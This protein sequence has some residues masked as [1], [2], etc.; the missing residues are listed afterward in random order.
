MDT[1]PQ[2]DPAMTKLADLIDAASIGMLTTAESGGSLRSRPLG[3][4]QIDSE[5]ALWFFTSIASHKVDD[6]DQHHK[7]NLS[8]ANPSRQDYV[9]I[10]GTA[11]LVNDRAKMKQLWTPWIEPWFPKG[12]E[13]PDLAL[14]RISVDEAEYWDAPDSKVQRLL[15]LAKAMA[16]GKTDKLGEHAKIKPGAAAGH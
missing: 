8:Y 14:L 10:S 13:D 16:T 3:T 9:S 15:G 11:Q 2:S 1:Q 6:I 12:V 5:G 7:V 4:L